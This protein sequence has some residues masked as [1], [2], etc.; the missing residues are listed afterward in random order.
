ME[1]VLK[2]QN[3]ENGYDTVEIGYKDIISYVYINDDECFVRVLSKIKGKSKAY[4]VKSLKEP[5]KAIQIAKHFGKED[6][7]FS[8]NPF[9]TM[10]SGARNN[11]FCINAIAIDVDYKKR[12]AFKD[13]EPM[14]VIKLLEMDFFDKRIPTPNLIEYGNQIRLIYTVDTCYIPKNRDNVVVLGQRISEV[15]AQELKDYGADKQNL[16]TYF[17]PP[18]SINTKN[19]AEVKFLAYDNTIRYTLRELQ[20][21]WLDELPKWYKKRKGRTKDK[22]KVVRLH[23]VYTLNCNRLSDLEKVQAYLNSIKETNYRARLCFLYRNF[24]LVKEKYQKGVLTEEDFKNAEKEMLRFNN[25]FNEPLR[26]H[27]IEVNTRSVNHTQYLFKNETLK[28]YLELSWEQCEE[29]GLDSIYIPKTKEKRN[30][31]Y[32]KKNKNKRAKEYK[33]ELEANGKLTKK[34]EVSQRRAK[35]KDLLAEGLIQKEIYT[36]LNISK[37]TC[38]SDVKFLKEQG[39]I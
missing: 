26:D 24:Y 15:F 3:I 5:Y 31:D 4:N 21:L 20:E 13:L 27:V 19:G 18:D 25:N 22:K 8:L 28:D 10:K 2:K 17:R 32:Y 1:A 34:Q 37:R 36:R 33:K 38:I 35:I 23:N 16:E 6:L 7:M 30:S 39:L 14:Q 9:R 29:I 11:L 12:E